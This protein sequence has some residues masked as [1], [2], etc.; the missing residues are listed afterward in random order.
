[1]SNRLPQFDYYVF[2][3]SVDI[4]A[5]PLK[6]KGQGLKIVAVFSMSQ[7]TGDSAALV[8]MGSDCT[9]EARY[10]IDID[11]GLSTPYKLSVCV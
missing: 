8:T 4:M 9:L 7:S 10:K 1:M 11:L 2:K 5:W 3:D 6:V